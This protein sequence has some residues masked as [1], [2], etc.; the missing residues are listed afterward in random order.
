[1]DSERPLLLRMFWGGSVFAILVGLVAVVS[2]DARTA[3]VVALVLFLI[4]AAMGLVFTFE[5]PR[6]VWKQLRETSRRMQEPTRLARWRV[7]YGGDPSGP[8]VYI[9]LEAPPGDA[10][11]AV[12]C[13]I[14]G[15]G[16]T[17]SSENMQSRASRSRYIGAQT[18]THFPEDF[19]PQATSWRLPK[20]KYRIIWETRGKRIRLASLT[21]FSD[22][23]FDW[24]SRG[25]PFMRTKL[26]YRRWR[27][28]QG[29][30]GD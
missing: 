12:R 17:G 23:D 2:G 15:P 22:G 27:R 20:G 25:K 24:E 18:W 14:E 26:R 16:Y 21:F 29:L 30:D 10:I 5:V 19:R 8:R 28:E 9:R 11:P 3:L 4:V 13:R 6:A 1:M 7:S